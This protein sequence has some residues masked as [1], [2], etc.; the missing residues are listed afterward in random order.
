MNMYRHIT[1]R[2]RAAVYAR[3]SH[4]DAGVSLSVTTQAANCRRQAELMGFT[5]GDEDVFLDDGIS[6]M[7]D[8]RPGFRAIMLT[9]FS[10]E[11]PYKAVFVT[12][13]SRLSRSSTNYF[14][15]EDIFATE[16]IELI[17]L[18]DPPGNPEV[19][20]DTNRR[21]KAV[22][23]EGQVV[24]CALKTR[25]C[26]MLAVETG[27]YIGWVAPLG[28]RKRKVMWKGAEHTKLERDPDTWPH[29]L[30][31]IDMAK[32]NHTLSQ[33]RRYLERTGLKHPAGSIERKKN[34]KEKGLKRGTGEW[35]N[36]NVSLL[37]KNLALLGWTSRGGDN[38]GSKIL[39]KSDQVICR[40]AHEAAM[41]EEEREL[42]L[43]NLASRRREVKHPG[44]HR[45]PN[46]L[47]E[48]VVCGMCGATMRMHTENGTQRLICANRRKYKKGDPKWCPNP[49]VRLD[50][51]VARTIEAIMGHI[52]TPKVVKR[53]VGLV[54]KENR[55]Y[56]A[57]QEA[58]KKQQGKQIQ[59]LDQEIGNFMAAIAEYGPS[60]PA[61][62]REIDRRQ[63]KKEL[64]QRELDMINSDLKEK[65]AFINEPDRIVENALTLRTYL[66]TE[67]KHSQREMLK[68]LIR[69]MSI[70][71]RV[72]TLYYTVPLPRNRTEEPILMERLGLDKKTCPSVGLTGMNLGRGQHG[73]LHRRRPRRRGDE[74]VYVRFSES[75]PKQTPQ[76]RG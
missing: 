19:K 24:D 3:R 66:D 20:I 62:G 35:T 60:N 18:M 73:H 70:V 63:E 2:G 50:I 68:S 4:W 71:T 48:L 6:G 44:I 72:A 14:E 32:T 76:A 56:V 45:S 54:A 53:E 16:G 34:R 1:N 52:L 65:L 38:S 36:E 27:F 13:I 49:S 41:T 12:D 46:P 74:P 55:K 61:Y 39:H 29:L 64:L 7:T 17:S 47:I 59:K 42:I 33:I 8:D 37:L 22:M 15:Y 43:R 21:M 51:L 5:V 9:L 25:A 23:N 10:P 28:Y 57:N 75:D 31:I 58:R 26:Q 11:R 67:D 40:G 69:K 30:H